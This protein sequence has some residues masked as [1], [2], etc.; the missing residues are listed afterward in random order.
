[1]GKAACGECLAEA[2]DVFEENVATGQ[3]RPE[4]DGERLVHAHH[5]R[6][7]AGQDAR[8][9]GRDLIDV[10]ILC[11]FSSWWGGIVSIASRTRTTSSRVTSRDRKVVRMPS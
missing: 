2:G 7:D 4:R 11:H 10:G 1:R 5:R 9:D 6:A 3:D 8:A